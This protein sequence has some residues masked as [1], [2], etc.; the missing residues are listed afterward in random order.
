MNPT[1]WHVVT[2]DF[3]PFYTGGV[4]HWS[5]AVAEELARRGLP[6]RVHARGAHGTG[7]LRELAHD[8]LSD[9]EIRRIRGHRWSRRQGHLVREALEEEIQEGD[10]VLATTWPVAANLGPLCEERGCRLGVVVQGS[11][12]STLGFDT[13]DELLKLAETAVFFAVSSFLARLCE[14]RGIHAEILPAPI[15]P[16]TPRP[17]PG[18]GLLCVARLTHLKGVERVL[19]LGRVLDCPVTIVG[20]GPERAA[21]ELL[22]E[23]L[24][25]PACF[26]GRVAHEDVARIYREARL[27]ALLSRPDEHGLSEE[28]L[29]LV[30]LEAAAHGVPAVVSPCGG[31]PEAVGPGLILPSPD[32]TEQSGE[33][34]RAWLNDTRGR[35]AF[36]Y[37]VEH[38]G[39]ERT[40]D[41]LLSHLDPEGP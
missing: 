32:D 9:A 33:R 13:P 1:R 3:S 18:E 22:A 7:R 31:L 39:P 35:E 16:Y 23:D 8:L 21:L 24:G 11:E 4:A 15:R 25:V 26:L 28:G 19:A 6:V 5:E 40:V 29:G 10:I 34:V 27:F 17:P 2:G 12:I 41:A 38:H 14:E 37:L 36:E 30:V 20:E